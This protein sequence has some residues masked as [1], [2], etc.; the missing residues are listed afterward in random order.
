MELV[1]ILIIFVVIL[2]L[3]NLKF[4]LYAG[5]LAGTALLLPLFQIGLPKAAE[6][7]LY[8]V[9]SAETLNMVLALYVISVLQLCLEKRDHLSRAQ[10]AMNGLLSDQRLNTAL[11]SVFIGMMPAAPAVII[12]GDMMDNMA[13]DHLSP[14]EKACCASYYRHITEGVLPTF[15]LVIIVCTLSGIP[16]SS[17]FLTMLPMVAVLIVLGFVFICTGFPKRR[18][19]RAPRNTEAR[20]RVPRCSCAASGPSSPLSPLFWRSMCRLGWR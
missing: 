1:K 7:T 20:G 2:V 9:T 8:S 14:A 19:G 17:F 11:A 18:R 5:M 15:P 4:P 13:G 6:I 3:L 12:C 10:N 16:V